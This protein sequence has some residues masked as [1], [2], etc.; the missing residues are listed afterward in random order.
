MLNTVK[1]ILFL[2][3][4]TILLLFIGEM[5]GGKQGLTIAFFFAG[6]MNFTAYW[7]SDK[8]VLSLYRA[9]PIS[10]DEAPGLYRMVEE[11]S[12][13]AKIPAPKVYIIPSSAPNAFA[14]GRNPGHSAV[15]VTEGLL[16]LLSEEEI[17]GV[18]SH[19]ISHIKNRDTLIST[20]AA[21]ISGAI[22]FLS[23]MLQWSLFF[24]GGE[25]EER[26]GGGF[27]LLFAIILAPIA[28]LLIQMAISRSREY[29]ADA[30][31]A[32]ISG[33]PFS[34]A[35]ALEKLHYYS[36]KIPL[37]AEPHTSH[38]FIISPLS[39]ESLITLFSTHPPIKKRIERLKNMGRF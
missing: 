2:T 13:S 24:L 3:L 1:T 4:L 7:F 25:R 9:K 19:E 31:G 35:S 16:D 20:V 36:K 33:N 28:A 5:A 34:L 37:E 21:T 14:T 30:S 18:L 12:T 11:L 6:I 32:K 8:I 10:R 22:M 29:Q 39:A 26:R 15:A 38:M 27:G 17:R 23:R